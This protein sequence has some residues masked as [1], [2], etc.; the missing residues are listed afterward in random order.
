MRSRALTLFLFIFVAV[1]LHARPQIRISGN[2]VTASVRP[3]ART[4]W[5]AVI[6]TWDG[7][8]RKLYHQHYAVNDDDGDG[9][10]AIHSDVDASHSLW[11]VV[12]IDTGEY[13]MATTSLRAHR[14]ALP[15]AALHGRGSKPARLSEPLDPS[16]VWLIRPGS[17][18]WAGYLIDGGALDADQSAN[19]NTE[20]SLDKL[21]P[22]F[23]GADV[24]DEFNQNDV[25][26]TVDIDTLSAS[27]LKIK[28]AVQP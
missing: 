18:V 26:I 20:V 1:S 7:D 9:T 24:I 25:L 4:V 3:H 12:E 5:M 27:D 10:V 17:N 21:R 15:D 28:G 19:G 2:D 16:I 8:F 14:N 22:L 13:D 11:C 23:G 6:N